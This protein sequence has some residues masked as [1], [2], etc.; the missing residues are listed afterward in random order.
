[1]TRRILAAVL[2]VTALAVV[3][4]FVPAAIAI[5]SNQERQELLELQREAA[6]VAG[7]VPPF[8]PIDT[9]VLQPA[10]DDDHRLSLYDR[11]GTL[12]GG[13]GPEP[14]DRL[15]QLGLAGNFAEGY[16]GEDVVAVVPLRIRGDGSSLV[17][18]IEAPRAEF[19]RTLVFLGVI[20][21][22]ILVVAAAVA[23][24]LARRLNRPVEDLRR[25]ASSTRSEERSTP[26]EPTGIAELDALRASLIE[27]R[28]RIEELLRRERSFSSHVSH[29]LR[30]PVAAMRIAVETELAAP[31]G[32]RTKV[33][34]ESLAQLDRLES[35][36]TSLLA[37]ARHTEHSVTTSDLASVVSEAAQRWRRQ[38]AEVHREIEVTIEPVL[39]WCDPVAVGHVLDVL[40]HNAMR[41][42]QGTIRMG[43]S[44]LGEH[45]VVDVAD[46][47]P[48]PSA[49]DVFADVDNDSSHGI[50]LRLA[51]TLVES[52]AGELTLLDSPTTTF[53]L[54][55]PAVLETRPNGPLSE[56]GVRQV[57]DDV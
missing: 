26:P 44:R 2:I 8:G 27:G 3:A 47:G 15:V 23:L 13:A 6:I 39:A 55:L 53:R 42:G 40:V 5:R 9:S 43:C 16:V 7:R 38:A 21:L 1:M 4:F 25:W 35:T 52:A 19:T 45:A 51:R 28:A 24:W 18:R 34:E 11:D 48:V 41:H 22:A 17:M 12:L 56:L 36:I 20:A 57:S 31:R 14:P 49:A 50:G 33:L 32:D 54:T 46:A 29:Q 30:T 10:V 37:L